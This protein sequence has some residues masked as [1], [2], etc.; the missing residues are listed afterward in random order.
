MMFE[1]KEVITTVNADKCK[2]GRFGYFSNDLKS[3]KES[4]NKSRTNLRTIYARLDVILDEHYE[5][6]FLCENGSFSLFYPMD[7]S[8]NTNRY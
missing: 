2:V 8:M 7:N 5:K 3:L 4:V 1:D 6:R